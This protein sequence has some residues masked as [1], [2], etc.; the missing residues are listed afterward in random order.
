MAVARALTIVE[1]GGPEAAALMEALRPLPRRGPVVGITGPMGV[2]KSTLIGALLSEAE[3]RGVAAGVL[4]VDPTSHRTGGAL[5]GDR[6]RM[7]SVGFIRS[8]A[9]RG[10]RGGI[11]DALPRAV[12]V[13]TRAFP[14][15]F[16]ET[17]GAGQDEIAVEGL[18]DRVAVLVSHATGDS[19][20]ILKGGLMEI[21]DLI[22]ATRA[23]EPGAAAMA[24]AV[25]DTATLLPKHPEVATFA[26]QDAVATAALYDALASAAPAVRGEADVPPPARW[27]L[28]HIAVAVDDPAAAEGAWARILGPSVVSGR[29]VPEQQVFVT[30]FHDRSGV[31]IELLHDPA[32][33]GPVGRFVAKKGPGLHHL[34]FLADDFDAALVE[35]QEAGIT[36]LGDP[37]TGAT[38]RR[39]TFFHPALFG[40]VLVELQEG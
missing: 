31:E 33:A 36:P 40:G 11:S 35:M 9:H 17:L 10:G 22:V 29:E 14:L 24:A 16:V 38:G 15:V 32:G 12:A 8:M 25:R 39:V 1:N 23:D 34:C 7:G 2:G 6:L 5:L 26:P 20:Q 19:I 37:T 27:R 28:S 21:A 3:R 13:M 18:V 30:F 4:A